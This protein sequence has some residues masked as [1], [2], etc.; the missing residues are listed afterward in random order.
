MLLWRE[1]ISSSPSQLFL[2]V[3]KP[4]IIVAEETSQL[5][6]FKQP[7]ADVCTNKINYLLAVP[8]QK[9]IV[10]LN[11]KAIKNVCR[12]LST[13]P[14]PFRFKKLISASW[15]RAQKEKDSSV[16]LHNDSV[17]L[18]TFAVSNGYEMLNGLLDTGAALSTMRTSA[19][20]LVA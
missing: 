19:R 10:V 4:M 9:S 1:K 11:D 12:Y 18:L 8:V 6:S 7:T 14:Q 15:L 3:I 17:V 20:K 13:A 16:G 2:F 5:M